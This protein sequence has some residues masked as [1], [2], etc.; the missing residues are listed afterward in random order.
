VRVLAE[1]KD[2]R[3]RLGMPATVHIARS[4]APK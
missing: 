2:D 1:D 3:L 4:Q